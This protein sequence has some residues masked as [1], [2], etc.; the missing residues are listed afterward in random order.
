MVATST[1][2]I[3]DLMPGEYTTKIANMVR[4]EGK[5]PPFPSNLSGTVNQERITSKYWPY[6]ERLA[7]QVNPE[8]YHA[9]MEELRTITGVE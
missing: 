3:R 7:M 1:T 4:A 9:R 5:V 8:A 2:P 6:I